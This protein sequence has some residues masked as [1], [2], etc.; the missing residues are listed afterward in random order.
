MIRSPLGNA[1]IIMALCAAP[2]MAQEETLAVA[3]RAGALK[4]FLDCQ[5]RCDEDYIR[6]E[7]GFVNYMLER[8]EADVYILITSQRTGAGGRR[9]NI[10][11]IGQG[12]FAGRADTVYA[13]TLADD[14]DDQQRTKMIAA[15][16][17]GLVPYVLGTPQVKYLSVIY[18]A[19]ALSADAPDPWNN[20]VFDIR[21]N[22]YSNGSSTNRSAWMQASVSARRVTEDWKFRTRASRSLSLSEYDLLDAD[23]DIDTTYVSRVT[24]VRSNFLLVKSVGEQFAIGARGQANASSFNNTDLSLAFRPA[25]EYNLYPYRESSQRD[26]R[27][28]YSAGVEYRQYADSTIFDK[29]QEL[30]FDHQ[31]NIEIQFVQPWGRLELEFNFNQYFHDLSKYRW[32]LQPGIDLKVAKGLSVRF[33]GSF[34]QVRDQ[35][36]LPKGALTAEELL[37]RNTD[38]A[39]T[40]RFYFSAGLSYNFGSRFNN[41]VNDRF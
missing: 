38:Q 20:W 5:T 21:G 37:L 26:F 17:L 34:T 32:S 6:R 31:L 12:P 15:I 35:L 8:Q 2:V 14:T 16:N 10:N 1:L 27:F 23:G 3:S 40:F 36:H 9:Y 25:I 41:V 18:N 19:P 24:N 39:T 33:D 4:V 22:M 13:V 30:L 11:M 28:N 7:V 29:L